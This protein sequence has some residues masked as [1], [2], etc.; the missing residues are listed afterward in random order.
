MKDLSG[1]LPA[2]LTPMHADSSINYNVLR[3]LAR[4]HLSTG[5][6][7]LYLCGSTG[8]S[9]LLSDD[10]RKSIVETV[11][12]EITG[13]LPVI[14]HVGSLS[15][16]SA[17]ALGR[18]AK[19]SGADAVSAVPPFYFKDTFTE[20]TRYYVDIMEATQMPMILYNIPQFTG[21][22]FNGVNARELFEHPLVVG[23]K[24]TSYDL[25]GLQRIHSEFPDLTLFNGHDETFLPALSIGVA[26]T[27]CTAAN[28][29]S[30]EM[31][32]IS[33]LFRERRMDEAR[34]AQDA[35][36]NIVQV[37]L[38][39]GVF[40]AAKFATALLGFDCGECRR[41]FL[42]LTDEQKAAV[43]QVIANNR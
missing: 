20:I 34:A 8:E 40:N 17:I 33:S 15:T 28:F 42:P 38:D 10:E 6:N 3:H 23:M 12:E 27:I 37:M 35:V 29:M 5:V 43:T 31:I 4:H 11:A 14:V 16:A 19:A 25:F 41:P 32:A 13:H 24:H 30:E 2:L 21:I 26:S 18:H 36:N 9:F 7:G 39:V 22:A 1:V